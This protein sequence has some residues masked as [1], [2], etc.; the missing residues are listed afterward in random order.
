VLP[1]RGEPLAG[2]GGASH[3]AKPSFFPEGE[4]NMVTGE[5]FLISPPLRGEKV[6]F[7]GQKICFHFRVN[8]VGFRPPQRGEISP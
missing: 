5:I 1:Q 2:G 6:C 4:K 8:G 3:W 7:G